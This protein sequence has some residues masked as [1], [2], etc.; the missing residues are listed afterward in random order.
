MG[1]IL[2]QKHGRQGFY[3]VCEHIDDKY[4]QD[5]YSHHRNFRLGSF[6]GIRI[7]DECW[8]THDLDNFQEFSE[9]DM[10]E[11]LDLPDE[12]AKKTE[13]KWNKVYDSINRC[14]WCI[15]CIAEVQI[16]QARRN[17][18]LEPFPVF[19]KTLNLEYR[20]KIAEL[21]NLLIETFKFQKYRFSNQPHYKAADCSLI[22]K[23][24]PAIYISAGSVTYPLKISIHSIAAIVQQDEIIEFVREVFETEVYN[25]VKIEFQDDDSWAEFQSTDGI[26]HYRSRQ[27]EILRE[28]FLNC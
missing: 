10:E 2:C 1:I 18:E 26:L 5:I 12:I 22:H 15:Q 25:Q 6:Y 27:G 4:K 24:R 21:E 9:I 28:V 19:E 23:D 7:C 11:F 20:D 8:K 13:D 3:E 16:K 14:C 17:G